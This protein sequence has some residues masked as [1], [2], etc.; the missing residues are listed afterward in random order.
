MN[1]NT[2]YKV[3]N[4][5]GTTKNRCQCSEKG[6][7]G[8]LAHWKKVTKISNPKCAV[9][10]CGKTA[11]V[12][13]HVVSIDQRTDQQW[14]IAPYCHQ[15]NHYTNTKEVFLKKDAVLVSANK[16]YTCRIG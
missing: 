5:N 15:H 14:W 3:K 7:R 12:G 6:K 4:L 16:A 11:K 10:G 9:L 1:K 8:W 2:H 13:A